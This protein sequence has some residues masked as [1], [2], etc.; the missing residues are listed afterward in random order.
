MW[1]KS[2]SVGR[3]DPAVPLS[4]NCGKTPNGLLNRT[5]R[6]MKDA[7]PPIGSIVLKKSEAEAVLLRP[8][9]W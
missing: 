9:P 8:R 3:A 2:E 4:V 1:M 6:D 7:L 5:R